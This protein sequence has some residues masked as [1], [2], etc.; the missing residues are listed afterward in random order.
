MEHTLS[1]KILDNDALPLLSNWILLYS[2][3]SWLCTLSFHYLQFFTNPDENF[4]F[5]PI[6]RTS[7]LLIGVQHNRESFP[8]HQMGR[9]MNIMNL[10]HQTSK[11]PLCYNSLNGYP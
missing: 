11:I 3:A 1:C 5:L 8:Q 7:D 4:T 10:W 2:L 9:Y 6:D